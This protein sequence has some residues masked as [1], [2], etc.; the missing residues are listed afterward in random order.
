MGE[1][2]QVSDGA[3]A[4]AVA[5]T[6]LHSGMHQSRDGA[7]RFQKEMQMARQVTHPNVCRVFDIGIHE[8]SGEDTLH[9]LTMEL[10]SGDTMAAKLRRDGPFQK[11]EAFALALQM[12]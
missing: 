11:A 12:A 9:F 3:L 6:T 10:L 8:L 2:Y 4:G 1:V 7:Q 5:L